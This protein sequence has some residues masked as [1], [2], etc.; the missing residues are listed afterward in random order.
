MLNDCIGSK[1]WRSWLQ[2]QRFHHFP[3]KFWNFRPTMFV[4]ISTKKFLGRGERW[5]RNP[6]FL[7]C[8][9]QLRPP[10]GEIPRCL[11][12]VFNWFAA[13]RTWLFLLAQG[14]I[15]YYQCN[16]MRSVFVSAGLF[17]VIH[18]KFLYIYSVAVIWLFGVEV[19][20]RPAIRRQIILKCTM[21]S[22]QCTMY[23][24]QCTVYNV[25]CTM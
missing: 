12:I 19:K 15:I 11:R 20:I 24:V 6:V 13:R 23:S 5:A 16:S 3:K 14:S 4:E 22:V 25:Q 7:G 8:K 1:K 9:R 17:F 2:W 10:S 18:S 21:Y